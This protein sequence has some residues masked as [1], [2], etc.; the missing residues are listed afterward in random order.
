MNG[1]FGSRGILEVD[2][3]HMEGRLR[4]QG[5]RVEVM[6]QSGFQIS[7][8][9]GV[10]RF[11]LP[12]PLLAYSLS[13]DPPVRP[14]ATY[15]LRITLAGYVPLFV[16]GVQVFPDVTT[17]FRYNMVLLDDSPSA[18]S[19][20]I[21][22]PSHQRFSPTASARPEP[23][24]LTSWLRGARRPKSP[25]APRSPKGSK[26]SKPSATDQKLTA[27]LAAL[28]VQSSVGGTLS[29]PVA[30]PATITV[31]LGTPDSDAINVNVPF[32]DYIKSVACSEI[33]PT[34][35]EQALRANII[36]QITLALN[37][38]YTEWYP[39]QGYD[40]QIASSPAFDQFFVYERD[41]FEPIDVLV[42]EIFNNYIARSGFIE[43]I[44]ARYCDGY[45]SS[46][47]G[48]SQWGTVSLAGQNLSFLQILRYYYGEDIELRIAPLE[49]SFQGSY[50]GSPLRKGDSG[51]PVRLVQNRLNRIAINYPA[52]PFIILPDG[53]YGEDTAEAVSTFQ[54][55][56]KLPQTGEVD[57]DTWYKILYIYTAVKGL[58]E[59]ESEGEQV[60]SEAYPGSPVKRG[61]VGPNVLRIQWYINAV[62]ASG[63]LGLQSVVL[64]GI[65]GAETQAAV[66]TLQREFG[67]E[68]TGEVDKKTW[69]ELTKLYKQ[70]GE[71]AEEE[72]TNDGFGTDSLRPFGGTPLSFG[73]RGEDVLYVQQ[74]INLIY[75]AKPSVGE[76]TPDG[77][78]GSRT[79]ASVKEFQR[80][81]GLET[82]GVVGPIT[83]VAL[84][85]Q[86]LEAEELLPPKG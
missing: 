75:R 24:V 39:S 42:D 71:L 81:R 10:S 34:W 25:K 30:V 55:I 28:P 76:L 13:P 11:V 82:D 78:F 40:F 37:R 1:S 44:F 16:T 6:G 68:P 26:P 77:I 21:T 63:Q 3:T 29:R 79:L 20:E 65:F 33:Y 36:A 46:C 73:S 62:S 53:I 85:E 5:A 18:S 22:L 31:H 57:E 45:K 69:D 17:V 74:V 72:I 86:A 48:L 4:L 61:D 7:D 47:D 35:P 43:P 32:I 83:W 59:L 27:P 41:I 54:G 70:L 14:Y 67:F 80:L 15:D 64:D 8:R 49:N 60:Q 52:L 19:K 50:P 38:V 23:S 66:S 9:N 2:L 51:E 58:A 84:N 12:A 56:F